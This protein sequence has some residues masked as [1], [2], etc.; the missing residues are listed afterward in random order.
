M[1]D[2]A[3]SFWEKHSGWVIQLIVLLT[4]LG[5]IYGAMSESIKNKPDR[6]EVANTIDQKIQKHV[7]DSK[8]V[9]IRIDQVPGL[10]EKLEL[11][12]SQM[13]DLKESNQLILQKI[14]KGKS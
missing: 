8:E 10:I 7:Q 14:M 5:A 13:K 6:M 11:I 4:S 9:Y 3:K 2:K 12:Q 1:T